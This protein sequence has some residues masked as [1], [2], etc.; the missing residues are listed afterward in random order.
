[1]AANKNDKEA[2]FFLGILNLKGQHVRKDINTGIDLISKSSEN[3]FYDAH[4]IAGVIYHEGRYIKRDI[5]KAIHFYIHGSNCDDQYSMNNLGIIYKTG[6]GVEKNIV[7]SFEL[8]NKAYNT[9]KNRLS[10]YNIAKMKIYSEKNENDLIDSIELLIYASNKHLQIAHKLLCITLI[11]KYGNNIDNIK[12]QLRKNRYL[13]PNFDNLI[14]N[15]IMKGKLN[16]PIFFKKEYE[17]CRNIEYVYN[18]DKKIVPL[19]ELIKESKSLLNIS[20]VFYEGF[21][22]DI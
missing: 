19:S 6:F 17:K 3:G 14:C 1:M 5:S 12:I 10:M 18:I 9:K 13:K 22:L 11:N 2:Q 16:N 21:G 7:R 15:L 20:Q 8:F 4:F